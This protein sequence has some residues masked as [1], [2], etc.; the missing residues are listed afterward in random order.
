MTELDV[1]P[2][3]AWRENYASDAGL[4]LEEI[5]RPYGAQGVVSF[6]GSGGAKDSLTYDQLARRVATAALRLFAGGVRQGDAV[7]MTITNTMSAVVSALGVWAAGATLVSVPPAPRKG[8][9]IWSQRFGSVLDAMGCRFFLTDASD[10]PATPLMTCLPIDALQGDDGVPVREQPIPDI[11]LVQFTSGSLG[12]PKGVAISREAFAGHIKMISRSFELDPAYDVVST[13]LP[14]YHDLG[15]VS[16][17]GPALYSRTPQTHADP[18]AFVLNPSLWMTMLA[19]ERATVSAA[20]NFGYRLA[21]RVP[22]PQGL[23]L[24]RMRACLNAAER[25]L[26]Q[27]LVDFQAATEPHGFSFQAIM[28]AYGLAEGTVGVSASHFRRGPVQGPG[29]HVSLG[30]PLG[31]NRVSIDQEK[32]S[33]LLD[34]DWLF[35]GYWTVD[36]F[37]PRRQR[38]Y[39]TND[40]A[41]IHD[42]ELYV[43][44][45]QTEVASVGGHNI[46]AEDVEEVALRAGGMMT[47]GA[48]AFKWSPDGDT[49]RFGLVV[50][51]PRPAASAAADLGRAMRAAV[52]ESL[53]TRPDPLFVVQAGSIPRTTSGK[54]RRAQ[55]REA[56]LGDGLPERRVFARL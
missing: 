33:L 28:P 17:F 56:C 10:N 12:I 26:W 19:E 22:Y 11:A 23:D 44:G 7:A 38:P 9:D 15:L 45:R 21:A 37:Q 31:G 34:G 6:R 40:G 42:G 50:E 3:F 2:D 47:V 52:S 1:T 16:M 46:F 53:R 4:S 14:L 29:G 32:G 30:R 18:R 5:V 25:V 27:D 41:F 51:V 36:G 43:Q 8:A 49:E 55:L 20:P 39:D 48:A 54:P 13:W 24:S 35:D